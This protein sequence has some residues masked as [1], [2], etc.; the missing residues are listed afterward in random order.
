LACAA[1]LATLDTY[2][3]EGLFEKAIELGQYWEDAIH[4]L[5]GLPNVIDIRN[6]GLIGAVE[7]APREGAPGARGYDAF[8]RAF[9]DQN[10]MVRC[11]GDVLALSPPLILQKEHIDLIF[12]RLAAT[13][14][15]TA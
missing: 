6:F 5:K 9:H 2:A 10:L 12:D 13:I 4:A 11:T 14:R 1:A 8:N 15:A 3:E 7:L